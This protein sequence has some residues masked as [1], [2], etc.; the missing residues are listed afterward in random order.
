VPR[1]V[2]DA[3]QRRTLRLLFISQVLG[4]VGVA[5]GMSVGALLAAEMVSVGVSGLAQSAVVLGGALAA[6]PAAR[7]VQRSGRR[8]SLTVLYGVAAI[9]A[10]LVVLAATSGSIALLFAGFFLF[11]SAQAASMQARYAA[12]DLSPKELYGRHISLIVWATTL[13]GVVGPNLGAVAARALGPYDIPP[14]AAPFG[15]SVALFAIVALVLFALM[16]PDPIAVMRAAAATASAVAGAP[17]SAPPKH[18]GIGAAW[19]AVRSNANATL[20]VAATAIGH[21]VMVGVMS[22]TPVHIRGAG[23]SSADTIKIV[24]V[25]ISIHIAGMYA[26]APL[27]GWLSDRFGRQRVILLGVTLLL[28]ACAVAGTAGHET[29]QITVVY[30]SNAKTGGAGAVGSRDG[31]RRCAGG[32]TLGSRRRGVRI[33]DA[34]AHCRADDDP[35]RRARDPRW[36]GAREYRELAR[37]Q[38]NAHSGPDQLLPVMDRVDRLEVDVISERY[39]AEGETHGRGATLRLAGGRERTKGCVQSGL[40]VGRRR[41]PGLRIHCAVGLRLGKGLVP[42]DPLEEELSREEPQR[43]RKAGLR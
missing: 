3:L 24:G 30:S 17:A 42:E 28:I 15:F 23:H 1:H 19:A 34:D 31:T 10:V 12:V 40:R 22:M 16:R 21:V 41:W 25:I 38:P 32:R 35:T 11:G 26:F 29:T 36:P 5:V 7:I 2:E 43:F 4:G 33:P 14:L 39:G 37:R 18:A 27:M 13:G 20:G 6:I 9:G 8:P